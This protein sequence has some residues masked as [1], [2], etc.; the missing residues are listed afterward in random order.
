MKYQRRA[1]ADSALGTIGKHV[2][3]AFSN[4]VS[5]VVAAVSLA[6]FTPL[7]KTKIIINKIFR[8]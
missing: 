4:D 3:K 7:Q 2:T 5:N 8:L 6:F 1:P